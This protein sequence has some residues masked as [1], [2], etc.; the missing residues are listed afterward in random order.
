[1]SGGELR[2][3]EIKLMLNSSYKFI[4]LDEPFNGIAPVV[5]ELL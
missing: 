2:Y 3:F 1:L 4:M 5:V